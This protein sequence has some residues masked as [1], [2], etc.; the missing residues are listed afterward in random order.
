MLAYPNACP[1]VNPYQFDPPSLVVKTNTSFAEAVAVRVGAAPE[2]QSTELGHV[3]VNP[4]A[5][6]S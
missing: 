5:D 1:A 2:G 4:D 3:T 6:A